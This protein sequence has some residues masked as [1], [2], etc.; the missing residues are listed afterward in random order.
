VTD[1]SPESY[2]ILI[3]DDDVELNALLEEYLQGFGHR[4]ASA[5]TAAAG[6][7]QLRRELPD[8]LILDVMLPDTD[9]LTLC[10]EFSAEY[11]LPIIMLTARGDTA[12]KVMGLELGADDY[13]AKPFEPRELVARIQSVIRRSQ[14]KSTAA[15]IACDGLRVELD[16][17]RVDVD[18]RAVELTTMEFEL[19]KDLMQSRG[20]VMSRDRLIERLRGFDADVYDRS[21]DMLVSRLREKLGD[22]PKQPRFIRTVRM[23]GYQFVG[24][25]QK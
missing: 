23:S 2:R 7:D 9:G 25:V 1:A 21:V 8:L 12:D 17:R 20:R 11:D 14:D 5:T 18:G 10:R 15:V 13:L 22:D 4:L 19:L 6:R 3:I 24:A 16:T